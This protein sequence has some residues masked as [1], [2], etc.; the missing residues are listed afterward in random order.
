MN[1][2]HETEISEVLLASDCAHGF[3]QPGGHLGQQKLGRR[4]VAALIEFDVFWL[5]EKFEKRLALGF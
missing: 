2:D 3:I 4:D 1:L 5:A